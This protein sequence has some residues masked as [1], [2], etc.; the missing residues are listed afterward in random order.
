MG[1]KSVLVFICGYIFILGCCALQDV[2]GSKEKLGGSMEE[3]PV[4]NE[5]RHFNRKTSFNGYEGGGKFFLPGDKVNLF[6]R[7][8]KVEGNIIVMILLLLSAVILF[9]LLGCW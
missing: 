6:C 3:G 5:I 8:L 9:F 4:F 7:G 2:L 1:L